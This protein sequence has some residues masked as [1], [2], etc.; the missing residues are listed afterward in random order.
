MLLLASCLVLFVAGRVFLV[1]GLVSFVVCLQL[2]VTGL[3]L[4]VAGFV[5]LTV[6]CLVLRDGQAQVFTKQCHLDM[7]RDYIRSILTVTSK[8]RVQS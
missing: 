2:L 4:L 6:F 7:E 8:M 3:E 5:L 1:A